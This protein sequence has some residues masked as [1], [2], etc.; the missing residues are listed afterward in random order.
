[1][2]RLCP[3][4]LLLPLL[5]LLLLLLSMHSAICSNQRLITF[6]VKKRYEAKFRFETSIS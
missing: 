1:M 3:R 2:T 4:G 5:P 6:A